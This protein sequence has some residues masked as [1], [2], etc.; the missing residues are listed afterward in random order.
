MTIPLMSDRA[1]SV[2]ELEGTGEG[3]VG[4]AVTGY[5]GIEWAFPEGTRFYYTIAHR[6]LT[7]WENG[8]GYVATIAEAPF[9]I[10][11]TVISSSNGGELV[12]FSPGGKDAF[13][14]AP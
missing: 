5:Q 4:P 3:L 13:V 7:E 14:S 2:V 6:T 8:I 1:R 9:L 10:R 11:E 12:D